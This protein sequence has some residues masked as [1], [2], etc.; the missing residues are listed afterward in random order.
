MSHANP[1]G[2]RTHEHP[3]FNRV[4]SADAELLAVCDELAVLQARWQTLWA[5]TPDQPNGG[6]EDLAFDTFTSFT[7]PGTRITDP[8]LGG[9]SGIDLPVLLLTLPATTPE[10]LQAKAAAGHGDLGRQQLHRRLPPG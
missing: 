8:A 10:G 2:I 9:A 7:W 1:G 3:T 5:A 4:L 6:P